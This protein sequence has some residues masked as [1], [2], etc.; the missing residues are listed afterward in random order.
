MPISTPRSRRRT[1]RWLR[2]IALPVLAASTPAIAAEVAPPPLPGANS[3]ARGAIAL[4]FENDLFLGLDRNYT[5][6]IQITY[7]TPDFAYLA[8]KL[9]FIGGIYRRIEEILP[10]GGEQRQVRAGFAIGH[11]VFTPA[12]YS[13]VDPDPTDRPYAG[14]LYCGFSGLIFN[15]QTSHRLDI[16]IG[17]VGPPSFAEKAQKFVHSARGLEIPQGWASQ[18]RSEVAFLI[19][20]DQQRRLFRHELDSGWGVEL[21]AQAGA[22]AGTLRTHATL[23][24]QLRAGW[25][26][27]SDFGGS[28]IRPAGDTFVPTADDPPFSLTGFVGVEGRAV[29]R[30]LFLDG[31]T[32]RDSAWVPKEKLVGDLVLGISIGVGDWKLTYASA[33]RSN[34]FKN[35]Q[36]GHRFASVTLSRLY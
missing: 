9:G 36:V 1:M 28:L 22:T 33:F 21:F 24:S 11:L 4:Y 10:S 35:Q 30:D 17:L 20:Y 26:L 6:G 23:G 29:A 19:S 27:P 3:A 2:L 5:N 25:R 14:Y 34:E 15:L 8:K 32:F 13:R 7:L 31:N 16:Q 18:L 12:D